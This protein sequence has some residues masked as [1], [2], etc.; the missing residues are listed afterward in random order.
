MTK[1]EKIEFNILLNNISKE[2]G[3]KINLPQEG[4]VNI[5]NQ[6]AQRK[7]KT[8]ELADKAPVFRHRAEDQ[9]SN[10]G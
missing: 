1:L 4:Q 3:N 7:A 2:M 10:L 5:L 6:K 8:E 9:T